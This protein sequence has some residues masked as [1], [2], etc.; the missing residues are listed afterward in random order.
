MA[1]RIM[2]YCLLIAFF[3]LDFA[4]RE[5]KTARR[6]DISRENNKSTLFILITLF[7]IL[8]SSIT[9]NIFRLGTF[10][11]SG[12]ARAG[13][14]IMVSGM[15]IR[16]ISMLTLRRFYTRTL[17]TLDD[18]KVL[19]KGIYKIIRHPGYLGTILIWCASG[20]AMSNII[21]FIFSTL[22][23][24]LTYHY[25][26]IAEE[27]MLLVQFGESYTKYMK[28]TWRLLPFIW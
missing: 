9:L 28:R 18:Q 4:I 17:M 20:L 2:A 25:R 8:L 3:I 5:N 11:N 16:S 10:K 6:I 23:I 21:V 24:L 15:F 26:I 27:K 19:E 13:L 22:L 1:E 12:L 14:F 7:F